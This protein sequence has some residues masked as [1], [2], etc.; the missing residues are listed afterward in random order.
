MISIFGKEEKCME[1]RQY[2]T[3]LTENFFPDRTD[4]KEKVLQGNIFA[5]IYDFLKPGECF[6]LPDLIGG[7]ENE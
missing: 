7:A 6:Y 2:I 4:L 5:P 3:K 1:H